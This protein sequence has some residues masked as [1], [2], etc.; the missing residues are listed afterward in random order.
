M[1]MQGPC[2]PHARPMHAHA[3]PTQPSNGPPVRASPPPQRAHAAAPPPTRAS[4][5]LLRRQSPPG[6]REHPPC[7]GGSST[8]TAAAWRA[9]NWGVCVRVGGWV[10]GWVRV[11]PWKVDC[12]F[13]H[14]PLTDGVAAALHAMSIPNHTTAAAP[15]TC[16][17]RWRPSALACR[18][19]AP[20]HRRP[21]G[22]RPPPETTSELWGRGGCERELDCM[23]FAILVDAQHPS[24][25][26]SQTARTLC[27]RPI[28][29]AT[30][31]LRLWCDGSF[32]TRSCCERG[33]RGD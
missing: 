27:V 10:G 26:L 31:H 16:L 7:A 2:M 33:D 30:S 1:P 4:L 8:S 25:R 9:L 6:S 32:C 23:C 19:P 12:G 17:R 13:I 29:A 15:L 3:K 24:M 5:L 18:P 22:I 14:I 28:Q 20:S 11:S 21:F